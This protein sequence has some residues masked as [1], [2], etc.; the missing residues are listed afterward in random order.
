MITLAADETAPLGQTHYTI[1]ATSRQ[2]L[3]WSTSR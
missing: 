3:R 1:T 2:T